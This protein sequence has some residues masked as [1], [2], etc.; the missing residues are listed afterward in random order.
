MHAALHQ[1][2]GSPE[3]E[4]LP[5]FPGKLGP[6]EDIGVGRSEGSVKRAE[7]TFGH[8]NIRVVDVS[9]NDVCDRAFGMKPV[10]YLVGRASNSEKIV[11]LEQDERILLVE[12]APVE[13]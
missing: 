11:G 9:V 6:G 5:D 4:R 2:L 7:E 10:T 8:A 1:Y 13:T 12:S 3:F